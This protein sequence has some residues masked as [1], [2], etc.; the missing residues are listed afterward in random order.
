MEVNSLYV[1][2]GRNVQ[3][4]SV[5]P[6]TRGLPRDLP[7]HALWERRVCSE[8]HRPQSTSRN[9]EVCQ[10]TRKVSKVCKVRVLIYFSL[11]VRHS[12]RRYKVFMTSVPAQ[13]RILDSP[14]VRHE[15]FLI[16]RCE[17]CVDLQYL[18]RETLSHLKTLH[19]VENVHHH[20]FF[21]TFLLQMLVV[22]A[23]HQALTHATIEVYTHKAIMFYALHHTQLISEFVNAGEAAVA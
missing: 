8:F 20:P 14:L 5:Y 21:V 17:Y 10:A 4:A 23:Y 18:I 2:G 6:F 19:V 22:E 13:S 3:R 15:D 1:K 16:P 11:E 9:F 7:S 12:S